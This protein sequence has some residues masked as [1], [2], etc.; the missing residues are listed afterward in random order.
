MLRRMWTLDPLSLLKIEFAGFLPRKS[1]RG[2]GFSKSTSHS[3]EL[4]VRSPVFAGG[5]HRLCQARTL[6]MLWLC[7]PMVGSRSVSFRL[8]TGSI[9]YR[10]IG[11]LPTCLLMRNMSQRGDAESAGRI[12]K[13]LTD[14]RRT[15]RLCAM[16]DRYNV[17]IPQYS[18]LWRLERDLSPGPGDGPVADEGIVQPQAIQFGVKHGLLSAPGGCHSPDLPL[19]GPVGEEGEIVSVG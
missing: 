12:R 16:H 15:L 18:Q 1:D 5:S 14:S 3:A 13:N 19:A 8:R 6:L 2:A 17:T 9:V 10:Q 11:K 7:L 4:G